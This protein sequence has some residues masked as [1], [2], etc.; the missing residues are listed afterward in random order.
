MTKLKFFKTYYEYALL[1]E[2]KS[3]VPALLTLA[4]AA[5]ESGWG[6]NAVGNNFFGIKVT[7]KWNGEKQLLTTTEIHNDGD[8]SKHPYP[9]IIS[10]TPYTDNN[11]Q[12]KYRWKVKDY[13]RSYNTPL[14]SFLDHSTF[15]TSNTRY[16]KAFATSDPYVFAYAI[17]AAGYATAPNYAEVLREIIDTFK[18]FFVE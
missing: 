18:T 3:K 9:V 15:L 13:F 12:I 17:A 14:D 8:R 7:K 10:I 6:N 5:L 11:N 4:Q 2:R 1:C 16:R